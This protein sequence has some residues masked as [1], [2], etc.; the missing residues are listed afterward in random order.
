MRMYR[1]TRWLSVLVAGWLCLA[2]G[3]ALAA[4]DAKDFKSLFNGKDLTGWDGDPDN[5]SVKDGV[6]VGETTPEKPAK[7]NTFLIARNGDED[8][9]LGDFELHI[10]FRFDKDH[11]WG[12]SGIQFRSKR[13]PDKGPNKWIVA[14][15]QADCDSGGGYD[16]TLYEERGRGGLCG[17]GQKVVIDADGKRQVEG[18]TEPADQVKQAVKPKGE[19]NE[20][21][22]TAQGDHIV[23]KLNGHVVVDVTDKQADKRALTGILALQLHAGEPMRIEFKDV[24]LKMLGKGGG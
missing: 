9:E 12:N 24:R 1:S 11:K 13:V 18:P 19:W 7:G 21:V 16:G 17:R 20:Y 22:I 15:Y 8:L 3:P 10:A 14:G 4:D 2:V 23:L 5:W 6:I